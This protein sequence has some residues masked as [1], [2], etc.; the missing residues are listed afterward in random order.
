MKVSVVLTSYNHERFIKRSIDSILN[1][2]YKNFEFIIVDDCSA[3]SSWDIIC[4]Y[5]KKYPQIVTIRHDF[6]WGGGTVE[7]TVKNYAT[8]E[9]IA[10]HHSDDV[11]EHDKLQKQIEALQAHPEC[12][13]IFSNAVAIDDDGNEYA[14]ESGFYYN[15]FSVEN[16]TRHEWLHHFFYQG[17]C[18]CHPSILIK[19]SVYEEDGFFRKGLRQIP[20]FVKWIQI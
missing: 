10:L 12:V 3:D 8:G 14:N 13:A 2:T 11:W 20:D 4:E 6:N 18:L 15:L 9:Y 5:K 17:N 1:Q 19:K 7:D 16:R